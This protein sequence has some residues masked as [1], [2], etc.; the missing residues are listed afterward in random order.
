LGRLADQAIKLKNNG[1]GNQMKSMHKAIALGVAILFSVAF[2]GFA[3]AASS[4]NADIS[5]A[6]NCLLTGGFLA[7]TSSSALA[8]FTA[9]GNGKITATAGELKV[10][11]SGENQNPKNNADQIINQYGFQICDYTPS[12]GSYS[13]SANGAGTLSVDWTA[14]AKNEPTP[15]DCAQNITT[16]F[17]ILVNSPSSFILDGTDL[18]QSSCGDPKIDYASCGSTFKGTC[19]AAKP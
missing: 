5:G 3:M 17:N 6:Y 1:G 9:G 7:Q 18:L 10:V 13:I 16:N 14:S 15:V 19:Q 4:P 2:G 12:G 11:V 8:Q